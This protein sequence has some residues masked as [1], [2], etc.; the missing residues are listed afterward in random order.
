MEKISRRCQS[1]RMGTLRLRSLNLSPLLQATHRGAVAEIP[2]LPPSS[3]NLTMI[4]PLASLDLLNRIETTRNLSIDFLLTLMLKT[5]VIPI[6]SPPMRIISSLI[7]TML[8]SILQWMILTR[9]INLRS[10]PTPICTRRTT[11]RTLRTTIRGS[12]L[13][14]TPPRLLIHIYPST[15]QSTQAISQISPHISEETRKFHSEK[16]ES[17]SLLDRPFVTVIFLSSYVPSSLLSYFAR[18]WNRFHFS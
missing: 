3:S 11:I 1:P 12:T 4:K 5:E 16:L 14:C 8:F 15:V 7:L 17:P 18:T 10:P 6:D 9:S 2:K 13:S